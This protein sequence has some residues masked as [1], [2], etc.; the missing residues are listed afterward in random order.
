MNHKYCIVIH[1]SFVFTQFQGTGM[2]FKKKK[3]G[4]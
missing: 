2:L 4:K 3:K 1:D